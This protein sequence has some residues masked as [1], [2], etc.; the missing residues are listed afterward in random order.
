MKRKK[1]PRWAADADRLTVPDVFIFHPP[2]KINY[3]RIVP[4]PGSRVKG[5]ELIED[6]SL[7]EADKSVFLLYFEDE[8]GDVVGFWDVFGCSCENFEFRG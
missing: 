8:Q 2:D 3:L 1:K 7:P 6:L 4:K 5:Q